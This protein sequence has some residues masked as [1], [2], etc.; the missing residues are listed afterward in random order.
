M[1]RAIPMTAEEAALIRQQARRGVL[2]LDL[3]G[4]ERILRD[5]ERTCA[6]ADLWGRTPAAR[7]Q[8]AGVAL[9]ITAA[10]VFV[11]GICMLPLPV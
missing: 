6:R 9:A 7:R 5:A 2:D 1:S 11:V 3:P 8:S 4:T 10:S